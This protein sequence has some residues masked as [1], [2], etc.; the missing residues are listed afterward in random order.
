MGPSQ[1]EE[2]RG[3]PGKRDQDGACA[4]LRQL[5]GGVSGVGS[6]EGQWLFQNHG[7]Y[8]FFGEQRLGAVL[9][10]VQSKQALNA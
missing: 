2:A 10:G 1:R 3:A 8:L 7:F 4:W 5:R 9:R 6:S